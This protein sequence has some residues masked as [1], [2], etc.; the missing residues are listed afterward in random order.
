MISALNGWQRIV[1]YF[2]EIGNMNFSI[3]V[4]IVLQL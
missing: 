4:V 1:A 2:A 3:N